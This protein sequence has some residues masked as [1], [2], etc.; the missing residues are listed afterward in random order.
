M[1]S[2]FCFSIATAHLGFQ[3]LSL[4]AR[5]MF[6]RA[7]FTLVLT[8]LVVGLTF[9]FFQSVLFAL[10]LSLMVSCFVIIP[11]TAFLMWL[12]MFLRLYLSCVS[13][14]IFLVSLA[15]SVHS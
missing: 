9:L 14:T 10:S 3:I 15:D 4:P 8:S 7:L 5:I 6:L 11:C 12:P 2:A 1:P 13:S